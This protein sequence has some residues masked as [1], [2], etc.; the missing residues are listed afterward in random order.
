[1]VSSFQPNFILENHSF[2][3]PIKCNV[4]CLLLHF[5]FN[6][7]LFSYYCKML[8]NKKKTPLS[9]SHISFLSLFSTTFFF[10]KLFCLLNIRTFFFLC[11]HLSKPICLSGLPGTRASL[12][13]SSSTPT[14]HLL[15]AGLALPRLTV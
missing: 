7:Q 11:Q 10:L 6:L 5:A 4:T 1:M 13:D 9:H 8:L 3:A 2:H 15:L 12:Q 14:Q